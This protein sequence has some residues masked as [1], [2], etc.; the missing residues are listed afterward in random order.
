MHQPVNLR[1]SSALQRSEL[2]HHIC[3]ARF[4][5]LERTM[6]TGVEI[7]RIHLLGLYLLETHLHLLLS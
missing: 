4:I 7:E 1:T 6:G 5:Y 2:G 3:D